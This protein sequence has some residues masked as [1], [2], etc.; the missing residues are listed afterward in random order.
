MV[1]M[2]GLFNLLCSFNDCNECRWKTSIATAKATRGGFEGMVGGAT[3]KV[4]LQAPEGT[5]RIPGK[6]TSRVKQHPSLL[7][8][9]QARTNVRK[10]SLLINCF[11]ISCLLLLF[12][13]YRSQPLIFRIVGD[14]RN[15][16]PSKVI[17][18]HIQSNIQNL[19]RLCH[20]QFRWW[21]P[22]LC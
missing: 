3:R 21:H 2:R 16:R 4:R 5:G 9:G 20:I 11:P 1:D 19:F 13:V 7:S 17:P 18:S 22:A 8:L 14:K 15:Y 12:R 10:R 6:M